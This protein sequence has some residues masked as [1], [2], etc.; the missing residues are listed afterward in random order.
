[1][2]AEVDKLSQRVYFREAS[3]GNI[4]LASKIRWKQKDKKTSLVTEQSILKKE[5]IQ[6]FSWICQ[7][8]ITNLGCWPNM[9]AKQ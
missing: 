3:T 1:L 2:D 9:K 7:L 5:N 8:K 4:Y 6:D